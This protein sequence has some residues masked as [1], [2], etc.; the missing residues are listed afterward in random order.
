MN[1]Q[2]EPEYQNALKAVYVLMNKGEKNLTEKELKKVREMALAIQAY[3]QN[4]YPI[5][6]P[7]TDEGKAELKMYQERINQLNASKKLTLIVEQNKDGHYWGRIEDIENFFPIGQGE[8]LEAL[9]QNVKD[10]IEDYLEHE[11]KE[12][13]VWKNVDLNTVEF[14]IVYE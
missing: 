6:E 8:T 7:K 9:I 11:G 1:I 2:S 14:E 10:A 3:E 12:D 4:L 13:P 5:E